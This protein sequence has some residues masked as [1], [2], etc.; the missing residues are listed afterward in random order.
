M[1]IFTDAGASER[2][3]KKLSCNKNAPSKFRAHSV[4]KNP[5]G[6]SQFS[7]SKVY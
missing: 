7:V 5:S 1:S 2:A 4:E 3:Y 6:N